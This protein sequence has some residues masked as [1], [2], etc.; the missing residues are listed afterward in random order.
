MVGAYEALSGACKGLVG[1]CEAPGG[2]CEA[3][4]GACEAS[5]GAYEASDGA[6]EAP[7]GAYKMPDGACEALVPTLRAYPNRAA[8]SFRG[9]S[10]RWKN[11]GGATTSG[12]PANSRQPA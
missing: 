6:C 7:D 1:A 9:L 3:P 12:Q 8:A 11:G 5:G 10:A 4:G 2:A